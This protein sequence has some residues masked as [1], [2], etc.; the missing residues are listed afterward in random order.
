MAVTS[1][2]VKVAAATGI[3]L[4]LATLIIRSV[5]KKE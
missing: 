4:F 5:A 2:D 1:K 3:C